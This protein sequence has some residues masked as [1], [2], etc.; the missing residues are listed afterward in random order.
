V[1]LAA[2]I[3]GNFSA[4]IAVI[5]FEGASSHGGYSSM[6]STTYLGHV[7]CIVPDAFLALVLLIDDL[8]MHKCPSPSSHAG[9][10]LSVLSYTTGFL[11]HAL[12]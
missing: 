4:D 7:G 11:R 5:A 8:S 6:S 12:F 3:A 10:P 9:Q 2:T 1:T